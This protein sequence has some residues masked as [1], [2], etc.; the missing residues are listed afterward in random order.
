MQRK[1]VRDSHLPAFCAISNRDCRL[2]FFLSLSLLSLPW[3]GLFSLPHLQVCAE[4]KNLPFTF[5]DCLLLSWEFPGASGATEGSNAE[6]WRRTFAGHH[7]GHLQISSELNWLYQPAK[8]EGAEIWPGE[9]SSTLGWESRRGKLLQSNGGNQQV[10]GN[11]QPPRQVQACRHDGRQRG[12][13][14]GWARCAHAAT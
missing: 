14:S 8:K 11:K 13:E 5:G 3:P 2:V 1:E 9:K 6:S 10:H 12:R 7:S 4:M